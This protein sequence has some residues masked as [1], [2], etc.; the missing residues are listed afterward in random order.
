MKKMIACRIFL[1]THAFMTYFVFLRSLSVMC[2]V[3]LREVGNRMRPAGAKS[4]LTPDLD[5]TVSNG[6]ATGEL[7]EI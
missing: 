2:R 6:T 7:E 3:A 1:N 4:L 5:Y